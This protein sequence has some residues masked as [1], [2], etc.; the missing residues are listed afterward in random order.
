MNK[1]PSK[2]DNTD[3]YS[4]NCDASLENYT[5]KKS[6]ELEEQQEAELTAM[7]EK[8][9]FANVYNNIMRTQSVYESHKERKIKQVEKEIDKNL[10]P[11]L[12]EFKMKKI[13]K[14]YL[15]ITDAAFWI[16]IPKDVFV[17]FMRGVIANIYTS[18]CLRFLGLRRNNCA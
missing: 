6:V 18:P 16:G 14:N 3:F 2:T 4:V 12:H 11:T 8:E 10:F 9:N 1:K 5:N 7:I 17:M 13:Q 15:K